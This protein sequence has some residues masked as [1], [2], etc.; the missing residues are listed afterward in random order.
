MA[1]PTHVKVKGETQ[2]QIVLWHSLPIYRGIEN[3][4]Q[5]PL[6][7]G[8]GVYCSLSRQTDARVLISHILHR[9]PPIKSKVSVE[10]KYL[11]P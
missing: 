2:L 9:E 3:E 8:E 5:V 4:N 10:I 7:F 11:Q 6:G 1:E